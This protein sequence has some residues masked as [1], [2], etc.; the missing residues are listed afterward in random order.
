MNDTRNK[1][2]LFLSRFVAILVFLLVSFAFQNFAWYVIKHS[3]CNIGEF[4]K[5]LIGFVLRIIKYQ[6]TLKIFNIHVCAK[7]LSSS[8]RYRY[9][10]I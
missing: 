3:Q 1:N 7:I 5:K 4:L 8:Y 9:R 10:H 6:K 2:I